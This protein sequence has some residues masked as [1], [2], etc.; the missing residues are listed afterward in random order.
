VA[1]YAT[2]AFGDLDADGDL[3]AFVGNAAGN[4]LLFQNTGTA[5]APAFAAP[6]TNPF[7][8]ADVGDYASPDV[9]DLDGDGDLDVLVGAY[10]GNTLFLENTGSASAPAFAPAA[11]NPFGLKDVGALAAPTFADVDADGDLD[12]FSG[13]SW[14]RIHF[15]ENVELGPGTCDDGLDNDADGAFDAGADPGCADA[16]DPSEKSSLQCDNGVDD[17]GD[18]KI[19]WRGDGSG[20]PQCASLTDDREAQPPPAGCGIGPELLALAPMF[21]ATRQRRER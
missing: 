11:T 15:L 7:G 6:S 4:S 3:D 1:A 5:G 10:D 19:D 9:A 17:D 8:L 21:A 18:G 12:V 16:N 20:D 13:N 14:G 2:P